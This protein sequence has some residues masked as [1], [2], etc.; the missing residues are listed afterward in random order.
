LVPVTAIKSFHEFMSG[1][2]ETALG[3]PF[4]TGLQLRAP[5]PEP[6]E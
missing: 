3:Q 1:S 4:F 6:A 5:A 2:R